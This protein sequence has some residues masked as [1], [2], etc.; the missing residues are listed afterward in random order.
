QIHAYAFDA[1][2]GAMSKRR[3]FAEDPIDGPWA[4][5]GLTVDAD[6][7]VWGAK[8]QGSRVVRYAP[9]GRVL[10]EL[11][12]PVSRVTS[13]MFVGSRLDTLAV[14]TAKGDE[15]LS[16]RVF[17]VSPGVKGVG[18]APVAARI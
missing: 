12:F 10:L 1:A 13:C 17:L 5:D 6:G 8:W 11:M 9:D 15:R 16:G 14:T 2:T 18:E 7:C 3:V 4:P